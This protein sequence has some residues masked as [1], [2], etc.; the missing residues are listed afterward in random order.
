[1]ICE[2]R[3]PILTNLFKGINFKFQEA[4]FA[5]NSLSNFWPFKQIYGKFTTWLNKW[6]RKKYFVGCYAPWL[7]DGIFA[8]TN[9]SVEILMYIQI[10]IHVKAAS[11]LE[12][13]QRS[14]LIIKKTNKQ[15]KTSILIKVD[16]LQLRYFSKHKRNWIW[17]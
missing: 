13:I 11:F 17:F 14:S 6:N 8:V 2:F 5:D 15:S 3:F 1:M 9:I 16:S 12:G 10:Y 4:K 7:K